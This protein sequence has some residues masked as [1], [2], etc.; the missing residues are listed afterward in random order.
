MNNF[1]AAEFFLATLGISCYNNLHCAYGLLFLNYFWLER[2]DHTMSASREKKQRQGAGPSEKALQAQQQQAAQKRKTVIYTAI[3]AVVAVLVAALLVW[4]T[5]FFQARATAATVG[6]TKLTAAEMSYYY[7]NAYNAW[8]NENYIYFYY[9]GYPVPDASDVMD[10]ATGQTYREYFL[11]T[12]L[13]SAQE[14]IVLADEAKKSGHTEAEVTDRLNAQI[15]SLKTSA[16]SNNTS[17]SAYLKAVYGRYMSAGVY[18]K[19]YTRYLLASLAYTDKYNELT[20]GYTEADLKAYYEADDHAD[21]LDTFEYSY[22]YFTPAKAEDDEGGSDADA[23]GDAPGEN[24]G[25]GPDEGAGGEAPNEGAGGEATDG[26]A[27]GEATGGDAKGE[28]TGGNIGD[29]QEEATLAEA[30]ANAEAALEALKKGGS[31]SDLAEQYELADSAYS[32]HTASVGVTSAPSA[33]REKLLSM[34]AGDAELVE[35]GESGYYVVTLHSR[36][37]VEDPT[38]DVR[39]ILARAETTTDSDG[40]VVAPSDEAWA[41]AKAR[42]EAIQAEFES[43]TKTEDSFAA[44]AN[45]KSDDGDGTTGGLY[46]KIDVGDTYVP[47]FLEWIFADGRKAGD[48]GIVKH[49]AKDT[50]G[51][52]YW[53]YHFIY[54]VG[55]NEPLWMRESRE[56]QAAEDLKDWVEALEANYEA[57]LAG[58]ADNIGR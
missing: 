58:G 25:D 49:E 36:K 34:K 38:K 19:L 40:K 31:V 29:G 5:G 8:I 23:D 50:D 20:D 18:E 54:L 26:D 53:G 4:R 10:S 33:I 11:E 47:E 15:Q 45:E 43:G 39:H 51:N 42:I 14:N 52:K 21:S 1:R 16:A 22:L 6:G 7:Y 41:A 30:K 44:L 24:D 12:A 3:G 37:L 55:D 57:A 35:N 56:G 27:D 2:I 17:Y 9:L 28:A 48:T 46:T 32:D 13:N